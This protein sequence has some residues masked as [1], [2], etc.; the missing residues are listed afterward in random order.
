LLVTLM[1]V[2][3]QRRE[4]REAH[5]AH[6][7]VLR[8]LE[9]IELLYQNTPAA[10]CMVDRE[11]RF[12]RV[13][14]WMALV[15]RRSEQEH[16]GRTMEE[17]LP[18]ASRS[19]ALAIA[20]RVLASGQAVLN[21]EVHTISSRDPS[22]EHWWL[23]SCHPLRRD[24]EVSGLLTVIQNVT[25]IKRAEL[26]AQRRLDELEAVYR[27]SPVGLALLDRDLRYLRVNEVLARFNGKPAAEHLGRTPGEVIPHAA[28]VV[29]PLLRRVV[30]AG[31]AVRDIEIRVPDLDDP[32]AERFYVVTYDP[33]RGADGAV[34]GIVGTVSDVT[35]LKRAEREARLHLEELESVYAHAPVGLALLDRD[36]RFVRVNERLAALT[37]RPAAEH[38]GVA[39]EEVVPQAAG[40]L[41]PIARR[42]LE[43]GVSERG[44]VLRGEEIGTPEVDRTLRVSL[45]PVRCADGA[46]TGVT[47]V[48]HDVSDLVRAQDEA[49][50]ARREALA[51]LAELEAV[52]REAPVGLAYLDAEMRCV[53]V[54]ERLARLDGRP[55]AEH[56]GRRLDEV[57]PA[58]AGQL[59]PLFRRVLETGQPELSAE[60]R[61]TARWDPSVART[62]LTNWHPIKGEARS[63]QGVILVVKDIT[64]LKLRQ[65]ELEEERAR[66]AKAERVASVGSWE[67]D[68]HADRVWW[69]DE[70]YALFG[71]DRQRFVPDSGSFYD[72]VHPGDRAK[73]RAQFE[74]TLR[75]DAPYRVAFRVV[76]NDGSERLVLACAQVERAPD[77]TP[78]RLFGTCQD[79]TVPLGEDRPPRPRRRS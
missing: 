66:L 78:L 79:V 43:S 5:E 62:W 58:L 35:A 20:R 77:G 72:H 55:V 1:D 21:E 54:N 53:R 19:Q 48:V 57:A 37:G 23:V 13:N 46:V 34:A 38:A 40:T 6:D 60:M 17:I 12:V 8:Q 26:E 52:Y 7:T 45:S 64:A 76:R 2:T 44:I 61:S 11:L 67:W 25:A 31:E 47:A 74:A 24:G 32:S 28:S 30:E 71:E 29:V 36:L 59:A 10:L 18:D 14:R 15:D 27:N 4:E 69:S 63:V 73:V 3:A 56:V 39:A 75:R 9:E 33:V 41:A 42:V 50:A 68:V 16:V 51:R 65:A 70:L 49:V 22:L